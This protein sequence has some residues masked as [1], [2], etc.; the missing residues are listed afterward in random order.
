MVTTHHTCTQACTHYLLCINGWRCVA[1]RKAQA[2]STRMYVQAYASYFA[3][4]GEV[5]YM[6]SRVLAV[7]FRCK[8]RCCWACCDSCPSCCKDCSGCDGGWGCSLAAAS[9][10]VVTG[11][12]VHAA[13]TA[14]ATLADPATGST[15]KAAKTSAGSSAY[16]GSA[17]V[18][19][20]IK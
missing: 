16:Q 7:R 8:P 14:L 17:Q 19:W 13:T 2:T 10:A 12:V 1:Q 11:C 20:Q 15:P 5:S 3:L 6:A 9:P 18:T 4:A